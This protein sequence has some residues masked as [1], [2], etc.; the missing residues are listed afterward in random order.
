M[1]DA[2]LRTVAEAR[3]DF[4]ETVAGTE[5]ERTVDFIHF[6]SLRNGEMLQVALYHVA[7]LI[8]FILY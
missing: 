6:H 1:D 4:L 2:H 3:H 5:E 8:D 7:L